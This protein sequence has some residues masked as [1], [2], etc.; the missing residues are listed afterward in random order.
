MDTNPYSA[1]QLRDIIY[2]LE[3]EAGMRRAVYPR[4]LIQRKISEAEAGKRQE[5]LQRAKWVIERVL[6]HQSTLEASR[7]EEALRVATGQSRAV[8][9]LPSARE[10]AL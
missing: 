2:E 3:R 8:G 7:T 1:A 10:E 6:E 9:T 5:R 4:L